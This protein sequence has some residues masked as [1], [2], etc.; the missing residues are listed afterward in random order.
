[1]FGVRSQTWNNMTRTQMEERM[2]G[3]RMD[4]EGTWLGLER[5]LVQGG[6]F[7]GPSRS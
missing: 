4:L 3:M 2:E 7:K 5:N 6:R 1:M